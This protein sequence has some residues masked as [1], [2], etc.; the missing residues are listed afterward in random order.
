MS[1]ELAEG[2]FGSSPEGSLEVRGALRERSELVEEAHW[3][4]PRS[5]REVYELAGSPQN[6][7]REFVGRPPEVRRKLVERS[8]DLQTL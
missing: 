8:L 7:F 3:N 5:N 2:F 4:S 1:R 6:G